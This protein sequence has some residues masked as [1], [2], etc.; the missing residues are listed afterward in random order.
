MIYKG[1]I[2][3]RLSYRKWKEHP[4]IGEERPPIGSPEPEHWPMFF[5]LREKEND[6]LDPFHE[7]INWKIKNPNNI[8][9]LQE[10]SIVE[11]TLKLLT[12]QQI[13]I[14]KYWG[15]GELIAKINNIT[16]NLSE[17]YR[18]GSP[19][20][21]R[22]LG[23]INAATNDVF[24]ITWF[25]KYMWDVAR[26]NQYE[27]NLPIILVTPRFPSYPSAHA[28]IAGCAEVILSYFFPQEIPYI[29]MLMEESALSR[30]YAS[31]HF[32]VDNDEGLKLGRQIGEMV[33]K[34]LK[35]QNVST[36]RY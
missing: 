28:T 33:V 8:D 17:K 22:V 34:L 30:L 32:K 15:T 7:R 19:Q 6:F 4:Y 26:P 2:L 25:F 20:T 29:K 36:F 9:W 31:V 27:R 24:V 10:I 35:T 18:L 11:Q 16:I 14:A 23:Y 12:P 3:I 5:I 21:S 1:M 13:Q